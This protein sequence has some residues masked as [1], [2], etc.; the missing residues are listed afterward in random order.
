LDQDEAAIRA[1]LSD[2]FRATAS[3]D[4]ARFRSLMADDVVFLNQD[5]DR[6][7]HRSV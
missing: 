1:V 2:W 7:R 6:R 5:P 4:V 3:G